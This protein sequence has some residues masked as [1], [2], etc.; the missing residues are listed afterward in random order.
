[1]GRGILLYST[2]KN[3][4][5]SLSKL[6]YG[7]LRLLTRGS[8]NLYNHTLYQIRQ[9]FFTNHEYLRYEE[10]YHQV[11]CHP[12][13]LKLPSQVAQQSMKLVDRAMR[14]FFSL[15]QK[16][17]QGEYAKPV[18]LP[19]Y[20]PKTGYAVCI[21]PKDS[22]KVERRQIRLSLGKT[23][24]E[25]GIR[26]L[27]CRLPPHLQDKAIKEV[28]LIPRYEGRYF[29]IEYVSQVEPETRDL[30][31]K[32]CLAIDLGLVNIATCVST[33]GTAFILEGKGLK[34]YNRWWNKQKAR[35]QS[36]YEKQRINGGAKMGKLLQKRQYILQNVMAQLVN[37]VIKEGLRQ[38]LGTILIGEMKDIKKETSLGR[39]TNQHFQSIPFGWFK[40]KLRTKCEQYGIQYVEVEE[41][42]TSQ[43]C[44]ECGVREKKYRKYRGLY[45]C[46]GCGMVRNADVN[47]AINILK[48]VAPESS[49]ARIGS[50]GRVDRPRRI[51]I[52]TVL[53]NHPSQEAPSFK[54]G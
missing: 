48:K 26:Y 24:R 54:S 7:I 39:M 36:V 15:L 2:Q 22:F 8:K 33:N 47:G 38:K 10:S 4:L 29:E 11:K 14:S 19:Q 17:Q 25:L 16:K 9:H 37:Y 41:A 20:L 45:V 5:R 1:M 18:G 53:E 32:K 23:C 34:S 49:W 46:G 28:R 31:M 21:F 30:D 51:R 52:P 27:Y 6:E 13:Y 42:Y 43:T 35:L 40:Q 12:I 3:H 50:R 44:S